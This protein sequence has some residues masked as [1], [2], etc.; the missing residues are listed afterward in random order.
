MFLNVLN[1]PDLGEGLQD[2][3]GRSHMSISIRVGS[4]AEETRKMAQDTVHCVQILR[5]QLGDRGQV[6]GFPAVFLKVLL[7]H[8]V[9]LDE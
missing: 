5:S 6:A 7:K 8:P 4:Q 1:S 9:P 2:E 3:S